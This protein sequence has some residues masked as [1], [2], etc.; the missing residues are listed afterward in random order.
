MVKI[1][2]YLGIGAPK[3]KETMFDSYFAVRVFDRYLENAS[4]FE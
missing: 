4:Y 3:G 2:A 1:K